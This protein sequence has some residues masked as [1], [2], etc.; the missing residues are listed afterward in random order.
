M[1]TTTSTQAPARS[2][3]RRGA[4]LGHWR[5]SPRARK[6]N[7]VLHLIVSI[8]WLGLDIGLLTLTITGLATEDPQ[9]LRAAYISMRLFGDLLLIPAGLLT[10][11]TGLV[12]SLGT[13]WGVTRHWWVLAKVVLTLT[14]VT[15]TIFSLRPGLHEAAEAAIAT[16]L[17]DGGPDS[18]A[19]PIVSLTM[20]VTMV[21]LSVFRP[22]SRTPW[23]RD[24]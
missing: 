23:A 7:L 8:T 18:L 2:P 14:A 15:L 22:W 4:N 24:R 9:T 11:L 20:Y 13:H 5:M 19:P 10:L 16:P 17:D 3:S 12:L 6:A 1:T 21:V